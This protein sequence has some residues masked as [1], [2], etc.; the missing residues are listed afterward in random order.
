MSE[1]TKQ[2]NMQLTIIVDLVTVSGN[3]HEQIEKSTSK[4]IF[5]PLNAKSV[6][7][8]ENKQK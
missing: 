8:I 3:D 7:S 4:K 2:S 6:L 5:S 1:L